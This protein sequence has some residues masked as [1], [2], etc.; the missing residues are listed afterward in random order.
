MD[1]L[2]LF[3]GCININTLIYVVEKLLFALNA[4]IQI[5]ILNN[6]GYKRDNETQVKKLY[7]NWTFL[8]FATKFFLV[9]MSFLLGR[10]IFMVEQLR[11]L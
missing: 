3:I 8:I 5:I 2:S 9:I 1:I 7:I 11:L 4:I 10:H 6:T